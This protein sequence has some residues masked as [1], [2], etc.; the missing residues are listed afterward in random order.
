MY[1]DEVFVVWLFEGG[2]FFIMF[3]RYVGMGKLVEVISLFCEFFYF[4][5]EMYDIEFIFDCRWVNWVD[6]YELIIEL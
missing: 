5:Y 1:V 4:I 3:E 6:F 2:W